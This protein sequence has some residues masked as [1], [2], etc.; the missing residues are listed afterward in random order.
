[1][2]SSA[3]IS[4]T[5][6]SQVTELQKQISERATK[7]QALEII[8]RRLREMVEDIKNAHQSSVPMLE[9]L[10]ETTLNVKEA[11]SD[12]LQIL[13]GLIQF[14]ADLRQ[15]ESLG[16]LYSRIS[17]LKEKARAVEAEAAQ[18]NTEIASFREILDRMRV[19]LAQRQQNIQL[20]KEGKANTSS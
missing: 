11:E 6:Q 1:M 17:Q 19:M 16:Q 20:M 18:L 2:A 10:K 12:A 15:V 9:Q 13:P 8:Q 5:L 3:P 4:S 7:I 14:I